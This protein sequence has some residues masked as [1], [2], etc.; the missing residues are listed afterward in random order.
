MALSVGLSPAIHG[1]YL[2]G[3]PSYL[4]R[5]SIVF[6]LPGLVFK[7]KIRLLALAVLTIGLFASATVSFLAAMIQSTVCAIVAVT[8]SPGQYIA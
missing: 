2:F 8:L 1:S 5:I 7:T 6:L 3:D 4:S